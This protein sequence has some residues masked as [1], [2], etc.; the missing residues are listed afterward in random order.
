M[1]AW[2]YLVKEKESENN[3][4]NNEKTGNLNEKHN[5]SSLFK[6]KVI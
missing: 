1:G 4:L 5:Q 3:I 6:L 2:S